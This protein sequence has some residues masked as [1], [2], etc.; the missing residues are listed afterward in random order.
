MSEE[1]YNASR[2]VGRH[3]LCH[4]HLSA[5]FLAESLLC[6]QIRGQVYI[7]VLLLRRV[8]LDAAEATVTFHSNVLRRDKEQG[9]R[10]A[11]ARHHP[12]CSFNAAN[13][14]LTESSRSVFAFA[15]NGAIPLSQCFS[16]ARLL[17]STL[18]WAVA[19]LTVLS[20]VPLIVHGSK[21]FTPETTSNI[22][23][24]LYHV[25][26]TVFSFFPTARPVTGGNELLHRKTEVSWSV[27]GKKTCA[28]SRFRMGLQLRRREDV[29]L[30]PCVYLVWL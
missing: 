23:G 3:R 1:L 12:V 2:H 11:P 14:V 28:R 16:S 15:R 13:S 25:F 19:F 4:V 8:D 9:W 7:I 22:F 26:T 21:N 5:E 10:V 20:I 29:E 24:S 17:P 18:V 6:Q 27:T 30:I